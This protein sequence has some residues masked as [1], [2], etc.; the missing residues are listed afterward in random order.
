MVGRRRRGAGQGAPAL[1]ALRDDA[2]AD[3]VL[4]AEAAL[5]IAAQ[6]H[7]RYVE[8]PA[9]TEAAGSSALIEELSEDSADVRSALSRSLAAALETGQALTLPP[10]TIPPSTLPPS[11]L[12]PGTLPSDPG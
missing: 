8:L 1:R 11:T 9:T 4:R 6:D 7:D 3:A 2:G 12:P 5:E 10:G